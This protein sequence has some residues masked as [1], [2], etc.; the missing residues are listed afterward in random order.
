MSEVLLNDETI[1]HFRETYRDL[2][3]AV[4]KGDPL[5]EAISRGQA[6]PGMEHWLPLF[7]NGVE[8]LFDYCP[9]VLATIDHEAENAI[10]ER[11]ESILDYYQARLEAIRHSSA[12]TSFAG[13]DIYHPV[14]PD[15][16]FLM[17][18]SWKA[19]ASR[20]A[21]A[22]FSPFSSSPLPLWERAGRGAGDSR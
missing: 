11:Q 3:G 10:A 20:N 18:A 16:A 22:L 21:H 5:Y 14:P 17:E 2:F 8:T 7:Y 19:L 12:K 13:G 9:Q 4:S 1:E 15:R 6:Y